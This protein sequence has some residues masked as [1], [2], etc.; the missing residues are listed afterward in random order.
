MMTMPDGTPT[1][2]ATALSSAPKG[3]EE[4]VVAERPCWEGSIFKVVQLDVEQPDGTP[5]VRDIVWH[6]GG[7]G[8]A[9][10]RG[11]KNILVF[12]DTRGKD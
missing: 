6:H 12:G 7:A 4:R 9:A 1:S 5:G 11:G 3:L 10:V 8:V 2:I